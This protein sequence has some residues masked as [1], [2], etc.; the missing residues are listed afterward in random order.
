MFNDELTM[1]NMRRLALPATRVTA[2]TNTSIDCICT[3][4]SEEKVAATILQTGLSDHTGQLCSVDFIHDKNTSIS[5]K[6][7]LGNQNLENLKSLLSIKNWDIVNN[8]EDAET[9]Y[10]NFNE[11]LSIAL[12]ITCPKR[13]SK[14]R[15]G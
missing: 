5:L 12:D 10:N 2:E 4:I 1:Q 13:K 15:V 7:K 14:T 3:S 9:A 6:R 11:I 8:A